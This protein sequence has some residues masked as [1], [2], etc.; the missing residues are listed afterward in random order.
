[1]STRFLGS[2]ADKPT[3]SGD[4]TIVWGAARPLQIGR[5]ANEED[6][7]AKKAKKAKAKKTKKAKAKKKK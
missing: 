6:T 4:S 1:L 5:P 3:E 7:M 2:F